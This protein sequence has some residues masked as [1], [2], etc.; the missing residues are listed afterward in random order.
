M[1]PL[2]SCFFKID[3]PKK[4]KKRHF[5]W[6]FAHFVHFLIPW[7]QEIT[8]Y[9]QMTRAPSGGGKL[10]NFGKSSPS[11]WFS[12]LASGSPTFLAWPPLWFIRKS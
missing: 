7:S 5:K 8:L 3:V 4:K 12:Y 10:Y 1:A 2:F 9:I 11:L 6:N